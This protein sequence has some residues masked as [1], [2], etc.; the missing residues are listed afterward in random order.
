MSNLSYLDI[1]PLLHK[2]RRC[3]WVGWALVTGA[4][5][6]GLK[7]ACVWDFNKTLLARN[8]VSEGS[9][10]EEWHPTSATPLAVQGGFLA[11]PNTAQPLT[12]GQPLPYFITH[13]CM[14]RKHH[15]MTHCIGMY[16]HM[17]GVDSFH[18]YSCPSLHLVLHQ[19]YHRSMIAR[20]WDQV[21]MDL[22][23][24]LFQFTMGFKVTRSAK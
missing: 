18:A 14:P 3:G 8:G 5:G 20:L 4:E 21:Y 1:R 22:I 16:I 2:G 24:K 17:F 6:S 23:T 15:Y 12:K 13:T 11:A 7:T 10:K 19:S 9:E